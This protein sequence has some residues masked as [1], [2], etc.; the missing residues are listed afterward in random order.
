MNRVLVANRG[1]IACR[2]IRTLTAMG[3]E[4]VAVYPDVDAASPHV[5]D[6][7]LAVRLDGSSPSAA[8]RDAEQLVAIARNTGATGLHPGYGFLS[9]NASFAA[10]VEDAGCTFIGPTP[11]QIAWFG[12]KDRARDAAIAA[13]VPLLPASDALTD[14]SAAASAALEIGLPVIVKS[15]AGGG[16]MGMTVCTTADDLVSAIE[17]AMRQGEQLFGSTS[18]I[19]ERFITHARHVEVQV[20]GDGDGRVLALGERDCS[21]QRRRQKVMEEAPA[22]NLDPELRVVLLDASRALLAPMRYRSAGTVEFVVDVDRGVAAFLEVNTRLQVEH[23]VTE[24]VLGLDLVEWMVRLAAGERA[25]LPDDEPCPSGHAIQV[26]CYAEDPAKESLPSAGTLTRVALPEWTRVDGWV[27]TGTEVSPYFDPLLAKV[28][29]HAP[30]RAGALH[31]MRAA[32]RETRFDGIETNRELLAAVLESPVV[33]NGAV[34]TSTLEAFPFAPTTVD[35]LDPGGET[36]VQDLPGRLGYWEVGVPPSGPFDDRSFAIGNRRL[37]ND[38]GTPGLECVAGGPTVRFNA[39]AWVCVTGAHAPTTLDGEPIPWATPVA[40]PAGG[41]VRVGAADS[42]GLRTY[43]LVRGGLD[44]PTYLGSASTFTLGEFGGHGGRALRAGDVLHLTADAASPPEAPNDPEA[45]AAPELVEHWEIGV[46]DGPHAAPEFFTH[47]DIAAV[48]GT[49]YEVHYQSSRTGVRLVG[50]KPEWARTDGGSAGLHP[51]N[52]HDTPY[53]P[54]T[55]DFTGDMPII[56]GPDGPSL[57]GFVCPVTVVTD[58]QW[59]IGQLAPGNTVRFVRRA[60]ADDGI[61]A[62]TPADDDRPVVTYRR[63]GDRAL[64]VEFGPMTLDF[65][66]RMRAQALAAAVADARLAGVVDVVPGIR[67]LQIRVDGERLTLDHVLGVVRDLEP[68]LPAT[69]ELEVPSRVVHLPLSWDDPA[70]REAITRY[71]R[72]VRDDAPWCPWNIEFIR[73]INGLADVEDVRRIVFD[74][75]YLVM[76]L[77]DVYLGAPVAVPVDPRHRLVTTKYNPA[78]TWTPENAVGIGG[79]YLC[80]YGMEG[81]GGYQFVGR[82]VPVWS[83][84]GA[85]PHVSPDVPWLLRHFDRIR[86]HPVDADELLDL[87]ADARAGRLD[88]AIEDST[89]RLADHKQ[90]AAEH[91]TS[92]GEF[93]ATR[94]AAYAEERAAWQ[95]SG[96]LTR[97]HSAHVAAHAHADDELADL[98]PGAIVV[99]SPLSGAVARVHCASGDTVRAGEPVVTVEAMKMEHHVA[100]PTDARIDRVVIG[101]GELVGTGTPL[102]VLA[103]LT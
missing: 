87:R 91:A 70:T 34:L 80:I 52:I 94:D 33:E 99:T 57:G 101:G 64:L 37:G 76:G 47:D 93:E 53:V 25:F 98:P 92:I 12:Q 54:G 84:Y 5:R 74:A 20:F 62:T 28:I 75:S 85:G 38:P 35:V 77:G 29:V 2:I 61:L 22:P 13:G 44:V 21:L 95:R 30:T 46:V 19:V 8:Y 55:L 45:G 36:T 9:E 71:M 40:V 66:L 65:D 23:G 90:F 24:E 97:D 72:V 43:L 89:F 96:E 15:V 67:S 6:A 49:D 14:V 26:R 60:P 63:D 88:L 48:Y 73:R 7:T 1:A 103:P 10:L 102:V 32:L 56:L 78:R 17:T 41:V 27:A 86:W 58:E 16:G 79:A 83:R 42:T 81:P 69:A 51:S 82:T 68:T 59:K 31:G 50:P 11:A 4:S 18:V 39:P 100:A 3:I